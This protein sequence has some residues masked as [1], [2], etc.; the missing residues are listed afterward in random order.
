MMT[1]QEVANCTFAK[2]VMGGYNMASVDDFLD[3]LTEDYAALYKE[4]AA[5]K[6]KLK[7]TVEKMSEY[8]ESEDAIR[9]TL[10]AAQKMST[11]MLSEAEQKR[12]KLI[13]EASADAEKRLSDLK[14]QIAEEEHRLSSVQFQVDK[15]LETERKRL[16]I[17]QEQ[18]R[19]F[20]RDVRAVCNEEL[21]QLE[22]L[23]ELPIE[24]PKP[25]PVIQVVPPVPEVQEEVSAPAGEV[26]APEEEDF[27]H[28]DLLQAISAFAPAGPAAGAEP[29]EADDPFAEDEPEDVSATRIM[30]LDELQF[31]PNYKKD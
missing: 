10:L 12:D 20:I 6:A 13:A 3:K 24:E 31:G 26:S 1:P 22:L 17:G 2:S 8:R 23:P 27:N 21:A 30:N 4:N 19:A 15:E 14:Q 11:A 7:M 18:L 9:S 5:L 16:T 28:D 25:E 29:E